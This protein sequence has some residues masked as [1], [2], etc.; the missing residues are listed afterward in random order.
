MGFATA[1]LLAE[2]G[3]TVYGLDRQE[4]KDPY[5]FRFLRA[6]VTSTSELEAAGTKV[7]EEAGCLCAILHFAG[8]YDLNSLVEMS[9]EEFVR[10][11]DINL[12][13]VYRINKLFL[14][15]LEKKSRIIITTSELAPLDPLPF[16]GIY[17]ITKTA[18][19]TYASSLRMELQLLGHKVSVI[20]PGAVKTNLLGVST[21]RL[22]AFCTNTKLYQ[23]NA[24]NFH[25][26]VDRV[27]ARTVEPLKIAKLAL[28]IL[29]AK[30][31]KYVY[32]I[33][34]NPLLLLL[35]ILPDSW[36]AAI[37]RMI[38]RQA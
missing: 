8:I 26:V 20:R 23:C 24:R 18:L 17:A 29:K 31:P 2:N 21:S 37:I 13:G 22:D 38:L 16:T 28:R 7:Q 6:D 19:D 9:E 27:E 14:P 5:S 3:Y 4:P 1:Q 32:N 34:R 11:F 35:N 25:A 30:R 36:Q 10:I 12:F 33:N 15:L